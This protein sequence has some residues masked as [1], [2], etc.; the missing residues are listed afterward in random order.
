MHTL[1][2]SSYTEMNE[3]NLPSYIDLQPNHPHSDAQE[4]HTYGKCL[5]LFI[6][7]N[8]IGGVELL[9]FLVS[10]NSLEILWI[11]SVSF[12]CVSVCV[13]VSFWLF[14]QC[15]CSAKRI[16]QHKNLSMRRQKSQVR[17]KQQYTIPKMPMS[18]W[19]PTRIRTYVPNFTLQ[20]HKQ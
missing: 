11:V 19:S 10:N 5:S 12:F 2:F 9:S 18:S 14:P 15:L 7:F 20:I 16:H 8:G 17:L 1:V 6:T 3:S 13:C 4:N